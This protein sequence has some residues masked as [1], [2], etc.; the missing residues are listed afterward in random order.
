LSR[1]YWT[2]YVENF[3]PSLVLEE[4][5]WTMKSIEKTEAEIE[6]LW[7]KGEGPVHLAMVKE[8]GKWKVALIETFAYS[9]R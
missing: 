7:R 1:A 6:I 2:A 9:G 5:K 8:H 3:D 4:S